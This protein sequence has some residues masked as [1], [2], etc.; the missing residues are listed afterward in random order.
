MIMIGVPP[1]AKWV[2]ISLVRVCVFVLAYGT[3]LFIEVLYLF[4]QF[5]R[6]FQKV[7]QEQR[8]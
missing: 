4:L 1:F 2:D 8:Y 7:P 6:F 5:E 3:Y